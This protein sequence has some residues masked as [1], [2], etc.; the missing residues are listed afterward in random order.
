M[1][2]LHSVWNISTIIRC[3]RSEHLL[4]VRGYSEKL[5]LKN[6]TEKYNKKSD[7]LLNFAT[8]L[9]IKKMKV[10]NYNRKIAWKNRVL[11]NDANHSKL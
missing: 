3:E 6:S 1:L 4:Y 7:F 8:L 9:I 11:V 5:P 10:N 2:R